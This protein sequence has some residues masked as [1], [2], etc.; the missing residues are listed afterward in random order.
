MGAISLVISLVGYALQ[1]YA[2]GP[3]SPSAPL[4]IALAEGA[5]PFEQQLTVAGSAAPETESTPAAAT[6]HG[7]E[8][9]ALRGVTLDDPI[10]ALH[11]LPAATS[12]DDFYSEFSIRG[13][14]FQH[15]GMVVDGVPTRVLDAFGPRGQRRRID[16]D[17]Q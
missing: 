4:E 17:A 15:A 13:L 7:R 14:D 9:Q 12:T 1:R 11:A 10:R 2:L 6:L 16:C 3:G 8:L 5:G